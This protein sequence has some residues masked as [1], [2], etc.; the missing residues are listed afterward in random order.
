MPILVILAMVP[1]MV[2]A[3]PARAAGQH[4]L[5]SPYRERQSSEIRGLSAEEI[6]DLRAGRGMGSA[7]AAELNGYPGPRHV[8]DAFEAGQASLTDEQARAVRGLFEQ[9]SQEARRLGGLIVQEEHE[10]E[11]AF[12]QGAIDETQLRRRVERIAGLRGELRL[13]HLRAH[14]LTRRLL[15]E[16]QILHYNHVRGYST[17]GH[18]K[19]RH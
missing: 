15:S 7:R 10:L 9:M 6:E 5:L 2:I 4:T 17:E 16:E 8:L 19:Q 13:V 11:A 14:L 18:A 12:R 1:V 3:V